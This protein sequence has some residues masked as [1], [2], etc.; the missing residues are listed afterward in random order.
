MLSKAEEKIMKILWRKNE[1]YMKDIMDALPEPKPAKST[2]STLLKRMTDKDM[3]R[4]EKTGS[5][6]K[7]IPLVAKKNYFSKKFQDFKT[8]FFN[9][10]STQFA[11]FFTKDTNLS[12]S[13]LEE[14]QKLVN[15]E[16]KKKKS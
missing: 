4:Y 13:E 1:A 15:E 7:Y 14:I 3:I 8:R 2:V 12:I 11:S 9:D 16:I 10:S 6:R 5:I